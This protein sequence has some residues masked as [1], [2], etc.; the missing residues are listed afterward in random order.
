MA[1]RDISIP[2]KHI[3]CKAYVD[4]VLGFREVDLHA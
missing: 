2:V 4:I 3:V 1:S